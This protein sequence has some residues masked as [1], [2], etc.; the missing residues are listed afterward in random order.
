[1]TDIYFPNIHN[2]WRILFKNTGNRLDNKVTFETLFSYYGGNVLESVTPVTYISDASGLYMTLYS[3]GSGGSNTI[4]VCIDTHGGTKISIL[5]VF[6]GS[7]FVLTPSGMNVTLGTRYYILMSSNQISPSQSNLYVYFRDIDNNLSSPVMYYNG[8]LGDAFNFAQQS[9]LACI[10]GATVDVT[11]QTYG[12][13]DMFN[14]QNIGINFTR[15][16]NLYVGATSN[17]DASNANILYDKTYA[18]DN[19]ST[20]NM[21][22]VVVDAKY[23]TSFTVGSVSMPLLF[24]IDARNMVDGSNLSQLFNTAQR[25]S[26]DPSGQP[27]TI[28]SSATGYSTLEDFGINTLNVLIQ[29][30]CLDE[31][32][33]VKTPNGYVR[34]DCLRIGDYVTTYKGHL[35]LIRN[36]RNTKSR[37]NHLNAPYVLRRGCLLNDHDKGE[38]YPP[39]DSIL[40]PGHMFLIDR[41]SC[42][43]S[44][45]IPHRYKYYNKDSDIHCLNNN[46]IVSYYHIELECYATDDL[47]INGTTNNQ[48]KDDGFVVES[49]GNGIDNIFAINDDGWTYNKI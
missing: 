2:S 9:G 46:Q 16:W 20:G 38:I 12:G 43:N 49:M 15:I 10:N 3:I 8:N 5:Y 31:S 27:P 24:Q 28:T 6:G 41:Y 33:M 29:T 23:P 18:A 26:K 36:I 44:W 19:S 47:V 35:S 11:K 37:A 32:T 42:K 25:D 7:Y 40:S 22:D 30:Y 13:I 45:S 21:Y 48:H 4:N 39:N 1:M 34:I 14:G 17:T